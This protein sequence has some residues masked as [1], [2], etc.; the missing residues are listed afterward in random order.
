MISPEQRAEIRRLY[1]AEH[2]KVGTIAAALGVHRDTVL[3]AIEAERF[4]V[5]LARPR[6]SALDPYLPLVRDTLQQYPRL[7]ATRLFEMLHDRGYKGS[8][9]QLRRTVAKLRPA[10]KAE[11]YLRLTVMAGEQGQVDWGSFGAVDVGRSKRPLS[12]F[13]MVLSWSR[14]I[15]AAF[16]LDQTLESFLRGHVEAF[17]FFAGVPRTLLYDYVA[18]HIIVVLC[19]NRL[20]GLSTVSRGPDSARVSTWAH[21][22]SSESMMISPTERRLSCW[23]AITSGPTRPTGSVHPGL[24]KPWSS[25]WLGS[26]S[27]GTRVAAF[28]IASRC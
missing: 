8:V 25:T 19:P 11:A 12:C 18:R 9:V 14:A 20:C 16:M 27:A 5:H 6:A 17:T 26:P 1:Y 28:C 4:L 23:S 3:S 13:V 2:W 15:H 24:G 10:P 7:R 22:G 21:N